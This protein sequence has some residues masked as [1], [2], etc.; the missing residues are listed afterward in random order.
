MSAMIQIK[1]KI[2][3][4]FFVLQSFLIINKLIL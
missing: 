3:I 4:D 1:I 2:K